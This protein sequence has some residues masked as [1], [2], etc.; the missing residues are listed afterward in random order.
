M[1]LNKLFEAPGNVYARDYEAEPEYNEGPRDTETEIKV[2][3]PLADG[4]EVTMKIAVVFQ[5]WNT[6][7]ELH[8][9]EPVSV[10][11][12][13]GAEVEMDVARQQLQ[14]DERD[15]PFETPLIFAAAQE[16]LEK[17]YRTKV[18]HNVK[19]QFGK[20]AAPVGPVPAAKQI[21]PSTV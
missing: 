17:Q 19:A 5:N 9:A 11:L 21:A 2:P 4:S 8:S 20:T 13:S 16:Y 6:D 10:I 3:Y 14:T 12:P 1:K 18:T 7:I 15:D